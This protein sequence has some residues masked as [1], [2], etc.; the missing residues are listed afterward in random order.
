[1]RS[2]WKCVNNLNNFKKRFRRIISPN[3][4]RIK[5]SQPNFY[6]WNRSA[7]IPKF[8]VKKRIGIYTGRMYH[9][10]IIRR[11]MIGRHFGEFAITKR[12]GFG[13]HLKQIKKKL[14]K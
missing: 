14:K 3:L 12:L 8:Y 7:I 6:I 2:A 10:L 11:F 9:S 4:L 1:M 5:G 13:I